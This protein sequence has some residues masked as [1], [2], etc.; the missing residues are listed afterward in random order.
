MG[1][2]ICITELHLAAHLL[3]LSF[4]SF[5]TFFSALVCGYCT[6]PSWMLGTQDQEGEHAGVGDHQVA[7]QRHVLLSN[8][9]ER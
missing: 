2:G 1:E 4:I 7:L 8:G 6:S 5:F 3:S 9:V